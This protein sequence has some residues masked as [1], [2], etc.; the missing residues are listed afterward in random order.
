[1]SSERAGPG[2]GWPARIL[3]T[4]L[5]YQP[6]CFVDDDPEKRGERIHGLLVAGT[7]HDIR[8]LIEHLRIDVVVLAISALSIE[9][10]REIMAQCEGTP[11]RIK[12]VPGLDDLLAG[13]TAT[14]LFRDAQIEDLLGRAPV[15]FLERQPHAALKG[16]VL[17]TGAAG[18][19][20]S[21]LC[22]QLAATGP[23]RLILLDVDESGLFNLA[24]ELRIVCQE[25][26]A[27]LELA[28]VDVTNPRRVARVFDIYRPTAVFHAAAYKHVPL[29]EAQPE[30]AVNTNVGG[31]LNWT[32]RPRLPSVSA[33]LSRLTRP[34]SRPTSWGRRNVW[35]RRWCRR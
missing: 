20:G 2:S 31:T 13:G 11:A 19:I 18:S 16:T 28:I 32:A 3:Q 27:E 21:E 1:M 4:A 14:A 33:C 10:R 26:G 6:V 15:S 30:E 9:A 8:E 12:I 17:V 5:G 22:K 35:P 24:A 7:R 34:S 25:S 23:G 29:M